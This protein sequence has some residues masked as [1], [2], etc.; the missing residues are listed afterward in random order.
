MLRTAALALALALP[1][2][3]S[4]QEVPF[5]PRPMCIDWAAVG[6]VKSTGWEHVDIEGDMLGHGWFSYRMRVTRPIWRARGG[7]INFRMFA[8][9]Y[10][11]QWR[12]SLILQ[13]KDM[14]G[15]WRHVGWARVIKGPDGRA[16]IP[17]SWPREPEYSRSDWRP[18]GYERFLKPV[19]Y[20]DDLGG[21][22]MQPGDGAP[23]YSEV[24]NGRLVALK[25]LFL[26]DLPALLA[27]IPANACRR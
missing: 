5:D 10:H 23:G 1:S 18:E 24:E 11:V 13:G 25:G 14:H 16:F 22:P 21:E 3:A 19:R 20:V 6:T 15:N 17:I 2:A 4:A 26:E 27:S 8:H 7:T 12:P 9:T